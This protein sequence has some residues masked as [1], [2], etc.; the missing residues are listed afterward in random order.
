MGLLDGL[1]KGFDLLDCSK[2]R[3]TSVARKL[4][5]KCVSNAFA[6]RQAADLDEIED[7][8]S[9]WGCAQALS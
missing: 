9:I 6:R 4:Q 8:G 2:A 7:E 5:I 1:F 3:V